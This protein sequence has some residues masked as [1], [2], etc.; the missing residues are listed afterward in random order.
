MDCR[1]S[2]GLVFWGR[3]PLMAPSA[4]EHRQILIGE[5]ECRPPNPPADRPR[6][7]PPAPPPPQ[8]RECGA[9]SGAGLCSGDGRCRAVRGGGGAGFPPPPL[10]C[11]C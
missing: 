11:C 2:W 7:P 5:E 6:I 3:G 10:I 4:P 1:R 9:R 8:E